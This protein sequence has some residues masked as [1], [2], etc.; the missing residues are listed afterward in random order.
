MLQK[1]RHA[2][3]VISLEAVSGGAATDKAAERLPTFLSKASEFLRNNVAGAIGNLFTTKD[4]GWLSIQMT[5]KP[6]SEMRGLKVRAPQGFKGSLAEYGKFL[7]KAGEALDDIEKDVLQPFGVWISQRISDPASLKALT[8]TLRIPGLH[9]PKLAELS[10]SLERFF[11]E[12]TDAADPIYGD[13][14]RRQGDWGDLNNTVKNLQTLHQNG[15][16]EKVQRKVQDL[17][18]LMDVL[19][20][21]LAEE[22]D[23][24]IAS[25]VTTEQLAKVTLEVAELIEYYGVVRHRTEEF[26]RINHENVELLKPHV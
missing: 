26:I 22:K 25:S 2:R 12:K 6:Y 3:D 5:R 14:F 8:N 4:L 11:P 7:E 15:K 24:F 10:K 9:A 21:R 16:Y 23:E 18:D 1:L 20:K 17:S 19:S 13:V